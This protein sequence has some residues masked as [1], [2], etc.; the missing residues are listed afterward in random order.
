MQI[1]RFSISVFN[2]FAISTIT[3]F[4]FCCPVSPL[5]C[6]VSPGIILFLLGRAIDMSYF[7]NVHLLNV[8]LYT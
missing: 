8:L 2:L 5:S 3:A 4:I 1:L 7:R 6:A